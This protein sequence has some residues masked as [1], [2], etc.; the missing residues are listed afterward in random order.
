[1]TQRF[2]VVITDFINDDLQPEKG[3]L[4]ELAG[5]VALDAMSEA[6][7][8]GRIETA[9]ALLVYHNLGISRPSIERLQNCRLIVR[10]GAGYNNIDCAAA[11]ERGDEDPPPNDYYVVN[12]DPTLH[13]LPVQAGIAVDMVMDASGELCGDIAVGCLPISM[14]E[15]AAALGGTSG[16][17]LR[18]MPYWLTVSDGTVTAIEQQYIP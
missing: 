15:W 8:S 9:D 7:L 5:V 17:L 1:M 16:A 12:E 3:V 18:S 13:A 10:C 11:R 4:G 14:A 6:E 2:H